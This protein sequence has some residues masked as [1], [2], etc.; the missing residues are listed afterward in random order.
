[1]PGHGIE[2]AIGQRDKSAA[3]ANANGSHAYERSCRPLRFVGI[4]S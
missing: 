2:L 1:M 3:R 4:F